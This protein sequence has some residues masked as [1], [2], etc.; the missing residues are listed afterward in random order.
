MLVPILIKT[1]LRPFE[2]YHDRAFH[3]P[4]LSK[5]KSPKTSPCQM[6]RQQTLKT[7]N[8]TLSPRSILDCLSSGFY[9]ALCSSFRV[10]ILT[11]LRLCRSDQRKPFKSLPRNRPPIIIITFN[12]IHENITKLICVRSSTVYCAVKY[13][14]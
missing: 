7:I 14:F 12:R 3:D 11:N 2:G 8:Q 13:H 6:I 9:R 5:F 4:S 10:I 1:V